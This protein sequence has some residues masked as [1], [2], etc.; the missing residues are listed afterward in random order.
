MII[1]YIELLV[2]VCAKYSILVLVYR[3]FKKATDT[4]EVTI[5]G[6]SLTYRY[7]QFQ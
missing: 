2:F 6:G 4:F 5:M 7:R 3:T 1:W